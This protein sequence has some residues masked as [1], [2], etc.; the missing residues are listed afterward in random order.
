MN[1]AQI[2]KYTKNKVKELFTCHKLA[3]HGFDHIERVHGWIVKIAR[4][5][6]VDLFLC[7]LSAWLHDVGRTAFQDQATAFSH[8]EASYEMCREW[9][10]HDPV[11]KQLSKKDKLV[12]LYSV[13]YHWNDMANKYRVAWILRDA[14]KIDLFGK[15]IIK[16]TQEVYKDDRAEN[17]ALRLV[18]QSYFFIKTKTAKRIIREKKL[19]KPFFK[20]Y[21]D[22][23]KKRILPV[24][25]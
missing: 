10:R 2:L 21:T 6:K 3:G 4:G 20:Y 24:K 9:F 22:Y 8:Q 19:F 14:D 1:K 12:I 18:F 25:L 16:R 13:R 5:E 17:Q 23:L 7:E 15:Q 11:L